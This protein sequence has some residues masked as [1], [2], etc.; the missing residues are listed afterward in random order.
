[1]G[2]VDFSEGWGMGFF[3]ARQGSEELG[4]VEETRVFSKKCAP[5][6]RKSGR[7]CG[8]QAVGFFSS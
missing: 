3:S 4:A 1:M 2:P 7:V 5:D 8:E 6:D